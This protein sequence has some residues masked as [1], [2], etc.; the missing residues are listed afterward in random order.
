MLNSDMY[1][2]G[3]LLISGS[4]KFRRVSRT[5]G[6]GAIC[7]IS[8]FSGYASSRSIYK[9][10]SFRKLTGTNHYLAWRCIDAGAQTHGS[11]AR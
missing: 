5:N 6:G 1:R 4:D 10:K 3:R 9:N 2:Y 7:S 11:F 8:I